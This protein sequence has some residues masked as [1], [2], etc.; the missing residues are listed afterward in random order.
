MLGEEMKA[1]AVNV[2][3]VFGSPPPRA[4]VDPGQL[5]QAM[6]NI[7]RNSRE[8]MPSG[9]TLQV[10][11]AANGEASIL[12]FV[13]DGEGIEPETARRAFEPFYS[14]KPDGTGLGLSLT[15]QIMAEHNGSIE[16]QRAG[17]RGTRVVLSLPHR[18]ASLN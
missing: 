2:E 8:A 16:I 3:L 18:P 4:W 10:R 6:L 7:V 1:H 11:T 12:E 17:E 15:E 9:G 13:D 14:T 5:R